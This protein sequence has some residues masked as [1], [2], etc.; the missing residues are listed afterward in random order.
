M[1]IKI[2]YV[3]DKNK[4]VDLEKE[5]NDFLSTLNL[6]QIYKI[7]HFCYGSYGWQTVV[8]YYHNGEI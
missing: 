5:I 2:F 1:K 6:G 4:E 3:T 7:E 8:I